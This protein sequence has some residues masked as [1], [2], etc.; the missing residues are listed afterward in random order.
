MHNLAHILHKFRQFIYIVA[1]YLGI[2][3]LFLNIKRVK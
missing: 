2:V 3:G 1:I